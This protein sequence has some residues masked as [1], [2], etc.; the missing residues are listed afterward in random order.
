MKSRGAFTW[1]ETSRLFKPLSLEGLCYMHPYLFHDEY[2]LCTRT[3]GGPV[4]GGTL[5]ARIKDSGLLAAS[6]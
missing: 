6:L 3:K 5:C 4:Q 1:R 2:I